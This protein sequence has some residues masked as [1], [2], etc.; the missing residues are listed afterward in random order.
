MT[1]NE[2]P[3]VRSLL[4][5]AERNVKSGKYAAAEDLYRQ[6][7]EEAPESAAA[8]IGLAGAARD[9][10]DRDVAYAR[11]M[12]LDPQFVAAAEAQEEESELEEEAAQETPT[13]STG[14]AQ[15]QSSAA[16]PVSSSVQESAVVAVEEPQADA[17]RYEVLDSDDV[18]LYCYR[19]PN[20]PTSLRCYKCN[21]PICSECTEKTPVGYLC[22]DC[23]REA[24]D[25][26]FNARPLDYLLAFAVAMPISL[27]IGYLVMRFSSG[28]FFIIIMFFVGGAVGGFIG[29]IT[30]RVI[31]QRRGRYI[32]A[33]VAACV[34]IGVVFWALPSMLAGLLFAPGAL[35]SL[36]GPGVY[37]FTAVGAAYYWAR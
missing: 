23:H 4:R 10:A 32:P 17:V 5:Q 29:R 33:L 22:P 20:R 13:S 2:T 6:I 9:Q 37:L 24:E 28:F 25:A 31:G 35:F 19:H 1:N 16:N 27:L 36:I 26:F 15:S 7:I 12:E 21:K 3:R 30:K 8:W 14:A 11:A 18:Q 34:I